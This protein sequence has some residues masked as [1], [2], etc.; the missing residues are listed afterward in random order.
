VS[1]GSGICALLLAG[2]AGRR[3]DPSGRRWKLGEALADGRTVLRASCDAVLGHVD[4]IAVVYGAHEAEVARALDGLAVRRV[5]CAQTAAGMGA[6]LKCGVL[7]TTPST[8]WLVVL[9]DMPFIAP[10]TL[11]SVCAALRRGA[12]IA[13]PVFAGRPGHPVGFHAMMREGLLS[14]DDAEGAAGLLQ[15]HRHQVVRLILDDPGCVRDIDTPQDLT[16]G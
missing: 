2:G 11:S 15:Q 14:I 16:E 13:R 4:E 7:A 8:G 1:A 12:R 10:S 3:F 5:P 6:S 9:G